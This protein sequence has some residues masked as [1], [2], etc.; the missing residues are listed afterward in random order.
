MMEFKGLM[1]AIIAAVTGLLGIFG[2][3]HK[4][5]RQRMSEME[6]ELHKKPSSNEIRLLMADKLAPIQVEYSSLT[7]RMDDV[8]AENRK[9]NDKMDKL[10]VLCSKLVH[11]KIT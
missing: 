9:I 3:S 4:S 1:F 10:L 7:R 5:L 8:Q 11:E 6:M 2:W